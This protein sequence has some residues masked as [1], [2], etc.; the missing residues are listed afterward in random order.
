MAA[1]LA[2]GIYYKEAQK[3]LLRLDIEN[4]CI[5][6]WVV[7]TQLYTIVKARLTVH[8]ISVYFIMYKLNLNK[9]WFLILKNKRGP[10]MAQSIKHSQLRS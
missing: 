8:L 5:L 4:V 7:I 1:G 10:W 3:S 6:S 2:G 9:K